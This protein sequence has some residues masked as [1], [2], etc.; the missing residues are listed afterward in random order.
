MG[1][2][3]NSGIRSTGCECRF[4][5]GSRLQR[6]RP[7]TLTRRRPSSAWLFV[8]AVADS[9]LGMGEGLTVVQ[10]EAFVA[11]A[12]VKRFGVAVAP[13]PTGWDGPNQT[14]SPAQSATA[15]A[16]SSGPQSQRKAASKPRLSSSMC[17]SAAVDRSVSHSEELPGVPIDEPDDLD[18]PIL[19]RTYRD[20]PGGTPAGEGFI[21]S[22]NQSRSAASKSATIE[23]AYKSATASRRR[24]GSRS[25][26]WSSPS[27]L[28]SSAL[29]GRKSFRVESSCSRSFD[30]VASLAFNQPN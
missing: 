21:Q 15:T 14:R 19:R 7:G 13:G 3:H 28:L 1:A 20:W 25:I 23:H 5:G 6:I 26:P 22:H 11:K 17:R 12:T 8:L 2:C 24:S 30:R 9:D 16:A 27:E 18:R 29:L 10:W 4:I